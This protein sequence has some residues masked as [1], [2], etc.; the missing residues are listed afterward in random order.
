M[1]KAAVCFSAMADLFSQRRAEEA[2][3]ALESMTELG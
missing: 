1:L 3:L 2:Q